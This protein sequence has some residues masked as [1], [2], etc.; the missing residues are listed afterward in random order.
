MEALLELGA[1]PDLEATAEGWQ[2]NFTP[3]GCVDGGRAADPEACDACERLLEGALTRAVPRPPACSEVT[4]SVWGPL[5]FYLNRELYEELCARCKIR[6]FPSLQLA[7]DA[8][9]VD[10]DAVFMERLIGCNNKHMAPEGGGVRGAATQVRKM[11]SWPINWANFSLLKLRS[12]RNARA[13][14]HLLGHPNTLLAT[15][16]LAVAKEILRIVGL[17]PDL[18]DRPV[19]GPENWCGVR[20]AILLAPPRD[21]I[22]GLHHRQHYSH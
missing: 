12:R 15:Q 18:L 14:S 17:S 5:C 11:P 7:D 4:F 20:L 21:L 22:A 2:P 1:S 9:A 6:S 3:L 8:K 19:R 13:S 16:E 10:F